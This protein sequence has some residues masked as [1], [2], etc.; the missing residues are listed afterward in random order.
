[1]LSDERRQ[2]I[3]QDAVHKEMAAKEKEEKTFTD[4]YTCR[5]VM[6]YK[7]SALDNFWGQVPIPSGRGILCHFKTKRGS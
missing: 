7:C 4:V 3:S 2:H 5:E 1:M 6:S